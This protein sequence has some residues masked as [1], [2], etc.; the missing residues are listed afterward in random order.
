MYVHPP[1]PLP[2]A[3][4]IISETSPFGAKNTLKPPYRLWDS[5]P[6]PGRAYWEVKESVGSA[7]K[8]ELAAGTRPCGKARAELVIMLN[9]I[10]L[11]TWLIVKVFRSFLW[12]QSDPEHPII[13][14]WSLRVFLKQYI[15]TRLQDSKH[16]SRNH[17]K[18][19]QKVAF[20]P[21]CMKA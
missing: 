9:F 6:T 16:E 14:F 20:V 4:V 7:Y 3:Q 13:T 21:V 18:G 17:E 5:S 8:Q 19:F 15:S 12:R 10:P 11:K 1:P 2:W